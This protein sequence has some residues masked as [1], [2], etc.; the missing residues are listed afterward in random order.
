MIY[1]IIRHQNK[2]N[3]MKFFKLLSLVMLMA[4]SINAT[5]EANSTSKELP[6]Y[7]NM[8][9]FTIKSVDGKS[10]H[11][12]STKKGYLFDDGK[13]K[14]TLL[15]LWAG[16]CKSCVTWLKDLDAIQKSY[17]KKLNIVSLEISNMPL[18]D[19]KA[20]QKKHKIS[21]PMLSAAQN[22]D[23]SSQALIKYQWNRKYKQGLPFTIV[24][25]YQGQTNSITKGV[26]KKDEYSK[27]IKNLIKHY[28]TKK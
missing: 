22:K 5:A 16:K 2:R 7:M 18:K 27:Y 17:P 19:I 15:V 14:I 8:D 25:G 6:K 10:M 11:L 3:K 23:F 4:V 9:E 21:Y 13:D 1:D 24:F 20:F 26:S 12:L 28:E